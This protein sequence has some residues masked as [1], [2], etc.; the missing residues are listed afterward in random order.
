MIA[1]YADDVDLPRLRKRTV[2][3]WIEDVAERY[4]KEVGDICYQFVN[5]DRILQ[6]N[7]D[8][9]D[10]DYY[11]D[12]I[13]FDE[14]KDN[15]IAGDIMISV[16][17]VRSN[18]DQYDLNYDEELHRVIIHGI[19][20]LCGLKDE[21]DEDEAVMHRAEDEALAMLREEVGEDESL[22]DE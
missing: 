6:T 22:L 15:V 11:T 12:I 1:F 13:T 10:H 3:R 20:H 7:Q 21:T 14:T 5:D 9:L 18:A 2:R 19:L 17:T 4:Q 8:F 16:D